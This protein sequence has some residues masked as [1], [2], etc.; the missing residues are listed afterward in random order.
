MNQGPYTIHS[1]SNFLS[2]EFFSEGPRGTIKKIIQF[3][4][5]STLDGNEVYN[6]GFGDYD[7]EK[8][9]IN[10]LIVSDNKDADKILTTVAYAVVSFTA[11]YPNAAVFAQGSTPSRTRFYIMG[12]AKHVKLLSEEFEIWGGLNEGGW[13]LFKKNRPYNALLVKHK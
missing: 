5:L 4:K 7:P 11:K 9:E 12:V 3:K 8:G 6:L 2:F 1:T 10:D 13:E